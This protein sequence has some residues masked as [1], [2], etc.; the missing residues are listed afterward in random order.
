MR[1]LKSVSWHTSVTSHMCAMT[2]C[3][4]FEFVIVDC[5]SID[6][7]LFKQKQKAFQMPSSPGETKRQKTHM[8]SRLRTHRNIKMD[9]YWIKS[10]FR[11]LKVGGLVILTVIH[12]VLLKKK[13]M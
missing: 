1:I 12:Q 8:D 11:N 10:L 4:P 3:K 7:I 9:T 5:M 13:N 6:S 2:Q